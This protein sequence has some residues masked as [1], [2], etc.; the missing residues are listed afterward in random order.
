MSLLRTA[1]R[2]AWMIARL[3]V[4]AVYTGGFGVLGALGLQALGY[5]G[6]LLTIYL[7]AVMAVF[8]C[9]GGI[10][11]LFG[12]DLRREIDKERARARTRRA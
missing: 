1:A 7:P 9:I 10:H 4:I 12:A 2:I 11:Y 8:L 5:S 3:L 6:E